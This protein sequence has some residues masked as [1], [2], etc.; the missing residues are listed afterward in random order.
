MGKAVHT[1]VP[2][3]ISN[4][5]QGCDNT[6]HLCMDISVLEASAIKKPEKIIVATCRHTAPQSAT[7]V[8]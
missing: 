6:L 7:K 5:R 4:S 3:V 2:R 8:S 1:K